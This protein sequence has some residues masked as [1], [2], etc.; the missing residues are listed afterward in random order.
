VACARLLKEPVDYAEAQAL[1]QD[2]ALLDT[3]L[4]DALHDG[5]LELTRPH[6]ATADSPMPTAAATVAANSPEDR[7]AWSLVRRLIR[8]FT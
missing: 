6:A 4:K 5:I 8:K 2:T 7:G 3:L 1:V